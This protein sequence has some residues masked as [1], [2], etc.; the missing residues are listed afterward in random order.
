[1]NGILNINK[2]GGWTSH[3]VVAWVRRVLRIKRVGHAGT[4]DP[5]A[6][7]VLLVCLGQATRVVEYLMASTKTYR[8]E[9][10]LGLT[11]DTYDIDGELLN[12]LPVP[13]LTLDDL[14]TTLQ[15]F[16]GAIMQAPPAYSA[17]KQDGVPL[18][19]R[20]RRG[21]DIRPAPRPVTIHGIDIVSWQTPC[22]VV[23][24]TCAAG[25][26]IR[27]LAH[28]L[29]QALGCGGTLNALE[30]TR[31]GDFTVEQ[32]V[33][34]DTVAEAARGGQ[35]SDHLH[36]IVSALSGLE[37]VEVQLA[38]VQR[39]RHGLPIAATGPKQPVGYAVA[40]DGQVIA[41]LAFD[42]TAVQWRP[43]KVFATDQ[44]ATQPDGNT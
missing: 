14:R 27:S 42:D 3:D 30:R 19:R 33:D 22:L 4:L 26:Y 44:P 29:G 38:D 13:E 31:S 18:H 15:Q 36:P 41:V 10:R 5:L 2:P 1:L 8:A 34:L 21:E 6:T 35:I 12:R 17:I 40:E 24:V 7:G 25:T 39:L 11:T 16:T 37:P 23:D 43:A 28:D 9:I 32:A 20:A